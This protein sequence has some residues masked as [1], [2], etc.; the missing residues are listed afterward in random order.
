[1]H[2]RLAASADAEAIRTL[3]NTE[4]TGSTATFDLVPR[5]AEEQLSWLEDHRGP[6]PAIVAV[7]DADTVVGF[8][9][10]SVYRDRPAYATTVENS[11]YVDTGARGKGVGRLLLTAL[12]DLATQ[13]GFHCVIARVGGANQASIALHL[14]CGFRM[15]G[16]EQE[17]G[18]KFSRW[19]DVSVLQR[20]L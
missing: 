13:H 9:S 10:L 3:Y 16:V 15:V 18:R 11:V 20:M 1:M 6:Y 7:D 17:V 8:G 4:V 14:A 12:I 2:V 19:L 5:T